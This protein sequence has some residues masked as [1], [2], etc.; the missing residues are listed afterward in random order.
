MDMVELFL[1]P[2]LDLLSFS[3]LKPSFFYSDAGQQSFFKSG[4]KGYNLDQLKS[5]IKPPL[6]INR[7]T[8]PRGTASEI[9][10]I[11]SQKTLTE[12]TMA[13]LIV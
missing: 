2:F 5:E 1:S 6:E 4:E 10:L 9:D 12:A 11:K 3:K 8:Y 13:D 7:L